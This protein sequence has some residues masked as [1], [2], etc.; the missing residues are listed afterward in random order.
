MIQMNVM[1]GFVSMSGNTEDIVHLL[2]SEL[3]QKGCIVHI[4]EL[5][6]L[7]PSDF[8]QYDAVLL[9]SYTWGDGDL[10]YEAEDFL[11]DLA[12]SDLNG[13]AAASFG[14][15]DRDYP[16]YCAAV[17][18]LE[19]TLRSAGATITAPGLKIE[20]DPDTPEKQTAC[21]LFAEDFFERAQ[22]LYA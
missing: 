8:S 16:K 12:D 19:Q 10:P 11:E 4:Q 5:D 2:Q 3:E 17:D 14:S 6:R 21:R 20:F 13:L 1:I 7:Y 15:G 22:R 18:L 9:G